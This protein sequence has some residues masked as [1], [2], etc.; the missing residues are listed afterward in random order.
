MSLLRAI[1]HFDAILS[2]P[3]QSL[4]DFLSYP[5][6]KRTLSM[7]WDLHLPLSL[8]YPLSA[9][10]SP[11][12]HS[13]DN[14]PL[15]HVFLP[16]FLLCLLLFFAAVYDRM[17]AYAS[18]RLKVSASSLEKRQAHSNIAFYF[19]LPLAGIGPFF[20]FHPALGYIMI[21]AAMLWSS[22][23]SIEFLSAAY[24][25]SR[26]RSLSY[27]FMSII[28]LLIPLAVLLFLFSLLSNI[29]DFIKLL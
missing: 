10:L 15:E 25:V 11:Y 26:A 16:F 29:N 4:R 7:F 13:L 2:Y 6:P 8:L 23:H 9:I 28:F 22:F 5:Y 20:F 17:F 12:L 14:F 1:R 3:R 24:Q 19:H 27:W 18:P 21:F